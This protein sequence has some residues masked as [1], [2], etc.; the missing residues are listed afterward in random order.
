MINDDEDFTI[1][2]SVNIDASILLINEESCSVVIQPRN[3][4]INLNNTWL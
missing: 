3:P 4:S 2:I 1:E